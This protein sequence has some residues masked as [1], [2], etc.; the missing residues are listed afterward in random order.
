MKIYKEKYYKFCGKR[1]HKVSAVKP[2]EKNMLAL[3]SKSKQQTR[4]KENDKINSLKSSCSLFCRL[5]I[6]AQHRDSDLRQKTCFRPKSRM[7]H[8]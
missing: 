8:H 7:M 4:S 2:L 5:L 3:F 6:E 1:Q